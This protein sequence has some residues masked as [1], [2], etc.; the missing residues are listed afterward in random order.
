MRETTHKIIC[1]SVNELKSVAEILISTFPD[2][3]IFTFYGNLGS[4]KT[5]FIKAICEF[6][7]VENNTASP[8]FSI[9]NQYETKNKN[10]IY[11][12]DFYRIKKISEVMDIGYE[13]YFYS[14]NYCF[15]EW[16]EK[17][18]KLLPENFVYVRIEENPVNLNSRIISF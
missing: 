2:D 11:H 6:L 5:T 17:I 15:I 9:V 1:N 10:Y 3:K 14:G 7:G 12:F 8:S 18:E 13:D 4:G 16:P